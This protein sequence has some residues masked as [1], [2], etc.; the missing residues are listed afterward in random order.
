M[1]E[2][3]SDSFSADLRAQIDECIAPFARAVTEISA[4]H[5]RGVLST[6]EERGIFDDCARF[7]LDHKPKLYL[8]VYVVVQ[9]VWASRYRK[10]N[11][12]EVQPS[13]S[14]LG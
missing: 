8:Q 11:H 2:R 7:I 12:A 3:R 6:A 14:S 1:K 5:V 13:D 10:Q 9:E 4:D